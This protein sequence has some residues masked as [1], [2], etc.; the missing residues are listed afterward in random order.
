[1]MKKI[2]AASL[3]LLLFAM[4]IA[5]EAQQ[6]KKKQNQN[7]E[8]PLVLLAGIFSA[9]NCIFTC[10]GTAKTIVTTVYVQQQ[11]HYVTTISKSSK[12][13]AYLGGAVAC[14]F[15]WPFI[16]YAVGGKE[17]TSEEALAITAS[18]WV[19]GLGIVLYLSN[20]HTP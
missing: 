15:L 11:E 6:K 12:Y 18:C 5:A 19:P 2:L 8:N 9:A 14:T 4:P 10:A 3:A 7:E 17:P 1:M 16:N 20:Q 13:G